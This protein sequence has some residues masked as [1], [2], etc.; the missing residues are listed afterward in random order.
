MSKCH[1][2]RNHMSQ[3]KSI[4]SHLKEIIAFD[5]KSANM[6]LNRSSESIKGFVVQI[7]YVVELS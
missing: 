2:V 6:I 3:L 4:C 7:E 1:I 5:D